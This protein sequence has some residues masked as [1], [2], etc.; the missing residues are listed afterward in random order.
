MPKVPYAYRIKS[1]TPN[2]S[3]LI[4]ARASMHGRKCRGS[5]RALARV[6]ARKPCLVLAAENV[7]IVL[8]EAAHTGQPR[9]SAAHLIAVQHA[10]V[11]QTQGQLC[12][13]GAWVGGAMGKQEEV[14]LVPL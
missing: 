2:T 13:G 14:G 9:Q 4:C 7:G 6:C 3:S 10:K 8:L 12:G 5:L 1:S 11:R